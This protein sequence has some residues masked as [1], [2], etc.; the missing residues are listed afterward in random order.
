MTKYN[1]ISEYKVDISQKSVQLKLSEARESYFDFKRKFIQ[2]LDF[3][4]PNISEIIRQVYDGAKESGIFETAKSTRE[5]VFGKDM[6]FYGVVYL[7]DAC[8]NSCTYCP[9]GVENRK[10]AIKEGKA[11]SLR[12]LSVDQAVEETLKVIDDGHSHVCYLAGSA[13]GRELLPDKMIPYLKAIDTLGLDEIIL[14]IEP[15]TLDGFK[16]MREAVKKTSLQFRV[17]QETYNLK[18]YAKEHPNGPKSDYHF[19]REAQGRA[20]QTG[21]DNVG[22][23]VLFGLHRFPIEEIDGLRI[24]EEEL[25]NIYGKSPA[26]ICLPSANELVN[27]GNKIPYFLER[28]VYSNEKRDEIIQFGDYELCNE[29]MYALGVIAMPFDESRNMII[30]NNIV[31]S[32]RDGP[33]MVETLD[34]Y[35]MCQTLGVQ[36][37]VG[38]NTKLFQC[39]NGQVHFEQ[40]TTFPRDP[41]TT[42]DKM[43]KKGFNPIIKIK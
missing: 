7:W 19:R 4:K 11:Y 5:L 33:G 39:D 30:P 20:I 36:A 37:S 9:G 41:K 16:K 24:H 43:R 26:R 10:K 38:G 40:A 8:V 29:L 17:F 25:I 12:E 15:A 22:I 1:P 21:F 34:P 35:G 3:S 6:H 42:I 31:H 27:I 2:E 28:G 18:T 14:N 32:E 23:G 13:P